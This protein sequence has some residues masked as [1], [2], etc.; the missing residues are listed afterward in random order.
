MRVC[1][2]EV[3]N[4]SHGSSL[5]R[6]AACTKRWSKGVAEDW[7]H[8]F[9]WEHQQWMFTYSTRSQFYGW[10][11]TMEPLFLTCEGRNSVFPPRS[12]RIQYIHAYMCRG[13][14]YTNVILFSSPE[15]FSHVCKMIKN[16][17]CSYC[18]FVFPCDGI[19]MNIADTH[20]WCVV[21]VHTPHLSGQIIIQLT[22]VREFGNICFE[23]IQPLLQQ[24]NTL[25]LYA[26]NVSHK[27]LQPAKWLSSEYWYISTPHAE[28]CAL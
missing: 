22:V 9:S 28:I 4:L 24:R 27:P 20:L 14:M 12:A 10:E 17:N 13:V 23:Q 18:C 25:R 15:W 7:L 11:S 5:S 3:S 16:I 6:L 19:K 1:P 2:S 21:Y 26:C 8:H